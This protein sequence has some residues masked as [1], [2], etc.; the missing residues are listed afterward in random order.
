MKLNIAEIIR[1]YVTNQ[2][3]ESIRDLLLNYSKTTIGI[4]NRGGSVGWVARDQGQAEGY[5]GCSHL[6]LL[7]TGQALLTSRDVGILG[8]SVFVRAAS[9]DD[10]YLQGKTFNK[11]IHK[12]QKVFSV[13]KEG[14]AILKEL[15]FVG[16]PPAVDPTGW[17]I[18][19]IPLLS[20]IEPLTVFNSPKGE[21]TPEMEMF[22][23]LDGA[24]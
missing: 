20:I 21:E 3:T 16:H 19:P 7:D 14:E 9:I 11:T 18:N 12:G 4:R 24:I 10:L 5:A 22:R 8:L 6:Y 2:N 13:T 1:N 15:Y 17:L 23:I